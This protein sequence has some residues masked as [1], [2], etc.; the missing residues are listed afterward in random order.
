MGLITKAYSFTANSIAVASEVNRVID[1]LYTLVNGNLNSA[2]IA[3]TLTPAASSVTINDTASYFTATNNTVENAL[4]EVKEDLAS[5]AGSVIQEFSEG[6]I[7]NVGSAS[8]QYAGHIWTLTEP[9]TTASEYLALYLMSSGAL[10]SDETT[11]YAL[12]FGSDNPVSAAGIFGSNNSLY[13]NGG[14][15]C[16]A[17]QPTLLDQPPSALSID[18]WIAP[19]DGQPADQQMIFVKRNEW[20]AT[21]LDN[22]M[23][24]LNS[25]GTLGVIMT[26]NGTAVTFNSGYIFSNG[27]C[28]YAHVLLSHNSQAGIQLFINGN[29]D[30]SVPSA[31]TTL[32]S[33]AGTDFYI[34]ANPNS[35]SV[36]SSVPAPF[37]GRISQFRVMSK[38]ITQ[39]DVDIAF[40]TKYTKPA[41]PAGLDIDVRAQIINNSQTNSIRAY[42]FTDVEVL[43]DSSN[44]YRAGGVITGLSADSR[45]KIFARA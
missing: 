41:T 38:Y 25:A 14:T 20:S 12:S 3:T 21:K 34:G 19:N 18:F 44:I 15:S 7:G 17:Y 29:L 40:A 42:S 22:I 10:V 27:S 4:I 8:Q 45:L 2:N 6:R 23:M 39:Q 31:V 35:A 13:F 30:T 26:Y 43:R 33:G 5:I 28:S 37:D 24:Y 11:T 16:Y 32:R 9:L 1:D 36:I